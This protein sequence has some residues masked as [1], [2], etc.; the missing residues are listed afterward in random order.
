VSGPAEVPYV[1][2]VGGGKVGFHLAKHLI[3][4]DYEVTL[5]EKD[6]ARAE[7]IQHQLGTVS[8]MVGDGDEM[9]FL[10][11][12]GIER[13]GVVIGCTGDDEDNLI[14]CQLAKMK[15]NVPRTIA[16]VSNPHN[17]AVF[18]ALGVD[19]PVSATELLMGLIEAELGS[20]MVRGVA[21]KA[22]GTCL[23]DLALPALSGYVGKRIGEIALP[24]GGII[25]CI[26]RAGK[27]VVPAPETIVE[28]GDELVVFSQLLD[29]AAVG[30]ALS[31]S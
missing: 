26:V 5:V 7:W 8:I 19:A 1:I 18:K 11:T 31:K 15:F 2:V 6:G 24:K 3:E 29:V 13:A 9:S 12:T 21:V 22:S 28:P 27:P 30:E 25:V 4:R 14:V 17:V 23:V 16:R 10:A 20:E